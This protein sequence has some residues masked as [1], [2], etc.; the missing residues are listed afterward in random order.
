MD[1]SPEICLIFTFE[2]LGMWEADLPQLVVVVVVS[3]KE[4]LANCL[5]IIYSQSA[6]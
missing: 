6:Q 1:L 5:P 2:L 3:W 4:E